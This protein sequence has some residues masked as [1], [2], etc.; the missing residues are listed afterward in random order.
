MRSRLIWKNAFL[1]LQQKL[2][3][4][5]Y[6][7]FLIALHN[8][9]ML[10]WSTDN[11]HNFDLYLQSMPVDALWVKILFTLCTH[12]ICRPYQVH[13]G[14]VFYYLLNWIGSKMQFFI[15]VR[16]AFVI[17]GG[18]HILQCCINIHGCFSKSLCAISAI[19]HMIYLISSKMQFSL[20]EKSDW[21]SSK[22][23][24]KYET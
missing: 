20:Q 8:L 6:F 23:D 24:T 5:I 16:N 1:S 3:F 15:A 18:L 11:S 7:L 9:H 12:A 4:S 14:S 21:F 17:F 22:W 10:S 2:I 13:K 19:S